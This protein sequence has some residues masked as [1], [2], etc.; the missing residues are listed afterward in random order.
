MFA[1]EAQAGIYVETVKRDKSTGKEAPLERIQVQDGK[2]RFESAPRATDSG[3]KSTVT[4]FKD[5]TLYILD[6][7]RKSYMVMD[8]ATME[9]T[10]NAM[11]QAMEKMRAQVAAMPPEKRAMMEKMMQQQGAPGMAQPSKPIVM[12]AVATGATESA[13]GRSCKVWNITHDGKPDTQVCVVSYAGLPGKDELQSLSKKMTVLF[14]KLAS[15]MKNGFGQQ[16]NDNP[17]NQDSRIAAKLNGVPFIT[18]HFANGALEPN[19]IVVTTW[20]TESVPAS[21]FDIPA[22]YTKKEMPDL[23]RPRPKN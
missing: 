7:Q 6:M 18:R 14:E 20:K 15:N 1:I 21:Q 12:D 13:S 4:I 5:E 16:M 11:G 9:R 22:D 2:G 10:A 8:R 3:L 19:E 23:Q 17:F